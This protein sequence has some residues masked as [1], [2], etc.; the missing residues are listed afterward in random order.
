MA[1]TGDTQNAK[2][3][4]KM[5]RP[6]VRGGSNPSERHQQSGRAKGQKAGGTNP[7]PANETAEHKN[8]VEIIDA[9][10]SAKKVRIEIPAAAVDANLSTSMDALAHDAELP[11]FR[12]GHVPRRLIEKKFG[13]GVRKQAKE[14][15]VAD[16]FRKAVEDNKLRMVGQPQASEFEKIEVNPGHPLKFEI[17]VEVA[18]DFK[19]PDLS[20]VGIKKPISTVNDD[21]VAKELERFLVQE[22]SLE[23]RETADGGDYLTGHAK[24]IGPDGK[25]YFEQDGIVVQAPGADKNGK[26]MIV[27]L[28]V[29]DLARQMGKPKAG[30]TVSVKAKGPE[31]YEF[32]QL[33]NKDITVEYKPARIDRIVPAKLE[34]V[35][36]RF[37]FSD[38]GAL[39]AAIKTR[40]GQRVATEQQAAMRTQVAKHLMDSTE[41]DLPQRLTSNQASRNLER[42]RLELM[43]RGMEPM[44]IE[45]SLADLRSASDDSAARELK[46]FFILDRA[47]EELGVRVTEGEINQRI[48]QIATERGERPDRLRQSLINNNQISGIFQQIREHKTIDAILAKA[49]VSEIDND[50]YVKELEAE[51]ETKKTKAKSKKKD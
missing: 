14:Q 42:R 28:V 37:G 41:M 51:H 22:G 19:L 26:G 33:R 39:K 25:T 34:D 43:Y 13:A 7:D 46:L 31:H 8:T 24:V 10:P 29:E 15:L 2:P 40:L 23:D 27:G 50:A 11:G 5:Q 4:V 48:T 44:K 6:A 17:E 18:P 47:A 12:K 3:V 30:D 45:E 38:E 35:T 21:M 20:G 49:S 9:G 32:E 16:A 36:A 1:Q